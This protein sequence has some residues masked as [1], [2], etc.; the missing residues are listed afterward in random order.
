[1]NPIGHDE[2]VRRR[3]HELRLAAEAAR[4]LQSDDHR[5][6]GR[7]E[8]SPPRRRPARDSR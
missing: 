5:G 3:E 2:V 8:I 4:R 7:R 1:M 6:W